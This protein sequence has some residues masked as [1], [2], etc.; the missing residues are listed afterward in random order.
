M[1]LCEITG[2]QRSKIEKHIIGTY[3]VGEDNRINVTGDVNL[4][5]TKYTTLP[6]KFGIVTGDFNL[7]GSKINTLEGCPTK[8]G[9]TFN[10]SYCK[11]LKSLKFC[12]EEVGSFNAGLVINS[13]EHF[14]KVTHHLRM[15]DWQVT[16]I[17]KLPTMLT[18]DLTLTGFRR[19]KSLEGCP[20]TIGGIFDISD[21]WS[22]ESFNHCPKQINGQLTASNA[23]WGVKNVLQF[24]RIKGVT[25]ISMADK[26]EVAK[27]LNKYVK[28]RDVMSA[29]EEL[30]EA[31]LEE[32]A[33]L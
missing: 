16:Y 20:T 4:L 30:I 17:E 18:G 23:G 14:P 15:R 9:G 31:G 25:Q 8:V 19:L 12:P 11:N 2:L 29:Q 1:K 24:L 27:I 33:K 13:F 26:P 10:I 22:L 21:C 6:V 32:Y 28:S 5:S 3:E 7:W